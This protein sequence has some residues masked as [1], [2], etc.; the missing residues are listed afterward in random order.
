MKTPETGKNINVL[1]KTPEEI[2]KAILCAV[3]CNECA[4]EADSEKPEGCSWSV[5]DDTLALIQ[6]LE[7]RLAQVERERDAAVVDIRL[8]AF[9]VLCNMCARFD[10]GYIPIPPHC[11]YANDG[12]CFRWR[13]VCPEN[14]KEETE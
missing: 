5:T 6:R 3:P 4:Y 11:K 9:N 1:S 10:E 2:K 14:T 8:M 13:G 7:S 12:K